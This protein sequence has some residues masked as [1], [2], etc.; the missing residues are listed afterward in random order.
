[1]ALVDIFKAPSKAILDCSTSDKT[2][3]VFMNDLQNEALESL[4][5]KL[6]QE[7]DT[8]VEKGNGSEIICSRRGIDLW[9]YHNV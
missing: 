9:D 2:I 8:T 5:K 1:M 3:L 7:L 6:S 4:S